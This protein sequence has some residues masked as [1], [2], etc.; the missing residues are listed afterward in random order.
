MADECYRLELC[1][2]TAKAE[3][4]CDV[5]MQLT[6][7][8]DL[9]LLTLLP[10]R[11]LVSSYQL[12]ESTNRFCPMC[13]A[14]DEQMQ[15]SKYDRLLWTI[16]CVTACPRHERRLM[17]E[18]K[19]KSKCSLPYTVPGTSRNN[20]HS[21]AKCTSTKA[22]RCEV[23]TA[24]LVSELLD[25]MSR[26]DHQKESLA[27]VFLVHAAESL[28][29][30]NYA[31]LA[32][33]LRLSKSQVH[34]WIHEGIVP[35]LQAVAR[36]AH[37]FDCTMYDVLFGKVVTLKLRQRCSFPHGLFSLKRGAG[38]RAPHRTLLTSL[39]SLIKQH[40]DACAKDAAFNLE[41][42]S[43]FLRENF[44]AQNRALVGAGRIHRQRMSQLRRDAKDDAYELSYLA[45]AAEG[46]YPCRRKVMKRLKELGTTLT[47]S[48]ERRAQ[49]RI[50]IEYHS[51][52]S[53]SLF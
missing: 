46:A 44:P 37:A 17:T 27:S 16:R 12:I 52:N 7:R 19:I 22:S 35:S 14:E 25:D 53:H 26:M 5:L 28:F 39:S 10:L 1:G 2:I 3:S 4:W 6:C 34:G 42:S 23:V 51:L 29:D 40:P 30:G 49:R 41:V 47:F 11:Y 21:L 32:R 13:Y 33:Y 24:R 8:A 45:L 50:E 9:H 43:K 20:G 15:R 18:P 48:D 31:A 38:H 36:I